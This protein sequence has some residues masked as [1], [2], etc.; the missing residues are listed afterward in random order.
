MRLIQAAVL[1]DGLLSL[2]AFTANAA[3]LPPTQL[4]LGAHGALGADQVADQFGALE[5]LF[6]GGGARTTAVSDAGER[7]RASVWRNAGAAAGESV[8]YAHERYWFEIQGADGTVPIDLAGQGRVSVEGPLAM[9]GGVGST[10]MVGDA[11]GG[12][13]VSG[14]A[15]GYQ[16]APCNRSSSLEGPYAFSGSFDLQANTR[17]FVDL[18]VYTRL[19]VGQG[20][21]PDMAWATAGM[22][23]PTFSAS[24]AGAGNHTLAY[25]SPAPVPEPSTLILGLAGLALLALQQASRGRRPL[26]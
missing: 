11:S 6:N 21:V 26:L 2:A 10:V 7:L 8:A 22:A 25:S 19:P 3:P 15:G 20:W 14:C 17:Y 1:A 13:V 4:E 12:L 16:L 23:L 9:G 18:W 5:S 24:Y